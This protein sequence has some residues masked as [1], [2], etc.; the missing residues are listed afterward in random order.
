MILG[1]IVKIN[2]KISKEKIINKE[3]NILQ[4]KIFVFQDESTVQ[5]AALITEKKI[6]IEKR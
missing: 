2:N 6:N 3:I 1:K 5:A 4:N